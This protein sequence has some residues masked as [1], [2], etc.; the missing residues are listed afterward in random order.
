MSMVYILSKIFTYVVLSPVIF[1]FLLFVSALFTKKFRKTIGLFAL[2]FYLLST[3]IVAEALLTPLEK[4]FNTILTE[5]NVDSVIVL[6][7]GNIPASANLPLGPDATKRALWG[8]MLAKSYSLP[9]LFSGGGAEEYKESDAFIEFIQEMSQ[10]LGFE[11]RFTQNLTL[12]NFSIYV[13][14]KSLDTY[15]NAKFSKSIFE[16]SGIQNPKICLVTS[17]YHME[18]SM[19]LY[20]HFGFQV[21][22]CATDFKL[23]PT[24]KEITFFHF[25]PN[26]QSLYLSYTALHEYAGLLSLKI[27]GI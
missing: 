18:R 16:T 21:T 12:N 6:S 10:T 1:I 19:K 4:P 2:S 20:K 23:G 15:E 9:L 7:G 3:F 25:V 26:F 24:S 13:E 8:L 14:D 17:A 11:S 5:L 27:R 22:P